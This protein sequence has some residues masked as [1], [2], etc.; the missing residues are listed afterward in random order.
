MRRAVVTLMPREVDWSGTAAY[1]HPIWGCSFMAGEQQGR[2]ALVIRYPSCRLR[3]GQKINLAGGDDRVF[4]ITSRPLSPVAGPVDSP[5]CP[6]D[7][8]SEHVT[9]L[10]R[11]CRAHRPGYHFGTDST[12][13]VALLAGPIY[14]GENMVAVIALTYP[15]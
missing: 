4:Y 9:F 10:F 15:Q 2:I 1:I 8:S 3:F 6:L 11:G 14:E 12:Y 5:F 7:V 13:G